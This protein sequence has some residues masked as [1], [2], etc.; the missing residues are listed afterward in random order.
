MQIISQVMF[1]V[2]LPTFI[3]QTAKL[4]YFC[5]PAIE[6]ESFISLLPALFKAIDENHKIFCGDIFLPS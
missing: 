3:R 1:S 5:G 6:P 2:Q 4:V